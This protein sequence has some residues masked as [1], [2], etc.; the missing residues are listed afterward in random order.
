VSSSSPALCPEERILEAHAQDLLDEA[1]AARLEAHLEGC[2]DCGDTVADFR[3]GSEYGRLLRIGRAELPPDLRERI[4]ESAASSLTGHGPLDAA[5]IE[6]LDD[7]ID[8]LPE[9]YADVVRSCARDGMSFEGAARHLELSPEL[10]WERYER[11]RARLPARRAV[12]DEE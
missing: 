12:L 1:A 7:L 10:V 5:P 9:E 8:S 2:S 4:I 6:W 3:R 11:V